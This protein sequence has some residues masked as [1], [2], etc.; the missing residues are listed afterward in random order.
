MTE[1]E[2]LACADP[3]PM[4]NFVQDKASKRK[5]LLFACACCRLIQAR[6]PKDQNQQR[7]ETLQRF[8]DGLAAMEEIEAATFR[9]RS[10]MIG[11]VYGQESPGSPPFVTVGSLVEPGSCVALI[12]AMKLFNEIFAGCDGVIAEVL[13]RSGDVVEFDDALYRIIPMP[14]VDGTGWRRKLRVALAQEVFGNPFRPIAVHSA[15]LA[16]NSATVRRIA[17]GIYNDHAFDR[18]PILADA[19]EDAGCDNADI[20]THCRGL[21][22]HVRGCWVID[23]LLGKE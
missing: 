13:F 2:W 15:V 7:I 23:L 14:I 12:E 5:L 17:H 4:L 9:V 21:G 3:S 16:W 6:C 10:P 8:A 19:L 1:A 18:L 20:L 11:R 22:P